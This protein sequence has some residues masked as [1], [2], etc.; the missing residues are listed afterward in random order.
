MNWRTWHKLGLAH[1]ADIVIRGAME[2]DPNNRVL[3]AAVAPKPDVP[4]LGSGFIEQVDLTIQLRE[5]E[6][7][8]ESALKLD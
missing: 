3:P 4:V 8:H 7:D 2:A 1:T 6:R 5:R